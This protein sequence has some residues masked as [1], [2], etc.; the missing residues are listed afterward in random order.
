MGS[1]TP[2]PDVVDAVVAHMNG[3]HV[4]DNAV[5]CRGVGGHPEATGAR[6]VGLDREAAEFE[7]ETPGGPVIVRIPFAEPLADRA[8]IRAEVARMFHDS[9]AMGVADD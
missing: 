1:W 7:A 9:V 5:I 8:Q 2:T 3:D 6:M 4:D